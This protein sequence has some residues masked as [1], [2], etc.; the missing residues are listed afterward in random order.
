MINPDPLSILLSCQNS[1]AQLYN[2]IKSHESHSSKLFLSS[3]SDK[4]IST[5]K[6]NT[7]II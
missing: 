5:I 6:A 4:M 1:E 2:T 7:Y 3:I